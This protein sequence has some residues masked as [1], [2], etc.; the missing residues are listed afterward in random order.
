MNRIL[1]IDKENHVAVVEAGV[2]LSDLYGL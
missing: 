2:I 1:E